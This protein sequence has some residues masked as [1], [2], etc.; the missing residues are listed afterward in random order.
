MWTRGEEMEKDGTQMEGCHSVRRLES[1]CVCGGANDRFIC[2]YQQAKK[3]GESLF[4]FPNGS[5][6]YSVS[7]YTR[8]QCYRYNWTLISRWDTGNKETQCA[9]KK[10]VMQW[11]WT[12]HISM[13]VKSPHSCNKCCST[14]LR[15]PFWRSLAHLWIDLRFTL[16]FRQIGLYFKTTTTQVLLN[17]LTMSDLFV[18]TVI[19]SVS[20]Y[21]SLVLDLSKDSHYSHDHKALLFSET[22]TY[23]IL[24]VGTSN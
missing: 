3:K 1:V 9:N 11:V 8:M 6:D 13:K 21:L 17:W 24:S 15:P 5:K 2:M 12:E 20:C 7:P 14:L 23:V 4:L 19:G 16:S 22:L 18:I 10:L